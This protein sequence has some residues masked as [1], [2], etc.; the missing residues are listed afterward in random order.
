MVRGRIAAFLFTLLIGVL[1]VGPAWAAE[2]EP[3]A[4]V[5][6]IEDADAYHLRMVTLQGRVHQ[7][8][9]LDPYF[10]PNGTACYGAYTFALEDQTGM[11]EVAVVGLCGRPALRYPE[12]GNG[13]HVVLQAE[14]HAPGHGGYARELDGTVITARGRSTVQAIAKAIKPATD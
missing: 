12:V 3:L 11:I 7:V 5:S 14:I 9:E 13:D 1:P 4:I 8:H 10:L 6:I 2:E